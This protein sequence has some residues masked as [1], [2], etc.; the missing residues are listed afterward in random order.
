LGPGIGLKMVDGP[1]HYLKTEVGC[2][3]A[4]ED[5][6]AATTESFIEGRV[7]ARYEYLISDTH[8]FSQKFEYLY[9][10]DDPTN[11]KV[12]TETAVT[13]GLNKFLAIKMAYEVRYQNRP[14]QEDIES[15][16]TVFSGALV[17]S[18]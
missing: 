11:Y 18:Y 14:V 6:S 3:W 12:A 15:T 8:R 1:V 7:F 5:Y 13:S 2:N 17:V 16:D 4:R 10:F 9:D